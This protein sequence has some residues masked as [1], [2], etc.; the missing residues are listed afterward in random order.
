M[1]LIPTSTDIQFYARSGM[2]DSKCISISFWRDT[3]TNPVN[4]NGFPLPSA[5]MLTIE[6]SQGY[7]DMS[8]YDAFFGTGGSGNELYVFR[9]IVKG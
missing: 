5:Q 4:I 8:Q 7:I 2:I 3:G 1:N 6:Q 9:T